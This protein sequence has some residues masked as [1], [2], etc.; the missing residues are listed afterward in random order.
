VSDTGIG[1]KPADVAVALAPFGQI[2]S[3]L[4]RKHVG[5]GLGLPICK[6]LMELHG[7]NLVLESVLDEGTTLTANFPANRAVRAA[8]TG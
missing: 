3:H 2:D 4:A 7:G 5:S 1:M 6:S 8:M